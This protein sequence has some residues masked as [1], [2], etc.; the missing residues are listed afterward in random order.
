LYFTDTGTVCA[1][2]GIREP[3]HLANH[4]LRGPIFENLVVGEYLKA[5]TNRARRP[6]LFFWRDHTGNEVDLLAGDDMNLTGVEIKSGSTVASDW[7]R[8]L[9]FFQ[10]VSGTALAHAEILHGGGNSLPCGIA[11]AIPWTRLAEKSFLPT[12]DRA[13]RLVV[14]ESCTMSMS[15]A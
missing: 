7:A 13:S 9:D 4:P 1:L 14:G 6:S 5:M 11:R 15:K 10:K 2:V 12:C 8:G 3:G